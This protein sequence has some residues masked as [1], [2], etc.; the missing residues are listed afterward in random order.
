[1][2]A[3]SW[4]PDNSMLSTVPEVGRKRHEEEQEDVVVS[5]RK[6]RKTNIMDDFQFFS[7]QAPP[8]AAAP[9]D[10]D[11]DD[12]DDE[13]E[14]DEHPELLSDRQVLERNVMRELVL[15]RRPT[16]PVDAKIEMWIQREALIRKQMAEQAAAAQEQQQPETQDD[17]E[18]DHGTVYRQTTNPSPRTV[19]GTPVIKRSSSLPNMEE[20]DSFM[21]LS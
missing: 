5:T 2:M 1:M 9:M 7:L 3:T 10:A 15:G 8:V 21:D 14:D 16:N 20:A 17:M 19:V 13:E 12:L 11:I 4:Q 18:L 6:R